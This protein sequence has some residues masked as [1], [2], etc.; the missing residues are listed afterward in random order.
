MI[1]CTRVLNDDDDVVEPMIFYLF[2]KVFNCL[3]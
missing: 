2:M 1:T 3:Y